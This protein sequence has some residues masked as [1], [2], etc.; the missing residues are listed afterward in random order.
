[1]TL[2]APLSSARVS[3]LVEVVVVLRPLNV[4]E[5]LVLL[6]VRFPARDGEVLHV[7][8]GLPQRLHRLRCY[9]DHH[10]ICGRRKEA[11]VL[12]RPNAEEKSKTSESG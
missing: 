8:Q 2:I 5:F 9:L 3:P 6:L 11:T 7:L 10:A 4:D 1:M 12:A